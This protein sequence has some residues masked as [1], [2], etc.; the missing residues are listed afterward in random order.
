MIFK[1]RSYCPRNFEAVTPTKSGG[2]TTV[3]SG[4]RQEKL[5]ESRLLW[6]ANTLAN[7]HAQIAIRRT[8]NTIFLNTSTAIHFIPKSFLLIE[9]KNAGK[10][11]LNHISLIGARVKRFALTFIGMTAKAKIAERQQPRIYICG[12]LLT[13]EGATTLRLGGNSCSK[14]EPRWY[15]P[16]SPSMVMLNAASAT[17]D[18]WIRS[19]SGTTTR[20]RLPVYHRGALQAIQAGS[21]KI[22]PLFWLSARSLANQRYWQTRPNYLEILQS[23]DRRGNK[24]L[25]LAALSDEPRA[26]V[27]SII[28]INGKR[29]VKRLRL[30]PWLVLG[31][32]LLNSSKRNHLSVLKRCCD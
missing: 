5:M 19:R 6:S 3:V 8:V 10:T 7:P 21:G 31:T 2:K 24:Q 15:C 22:K 18:E 14:S 20:S 26:N 13:A 17:A 1:T 16:L 12:T 29:K 25:I 30:P 28:E 23:R 4:C 9:S 32:K 11:I 27:F